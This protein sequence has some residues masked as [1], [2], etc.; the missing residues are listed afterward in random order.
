MMFPASPASPG[1]PGPV[2]ELADLSKDYHGLRPLRIEKL[3]LAEG[4]LVAILG[5]DQPMAET[6]VNLV[7]GATLPDRGEVSIFGRQ[8]SAIRDSADWLSVVDR[9]GIVSERAVL[10]DAL[11]VIQNL[12]IPFTL[13][14]DPVPGD[15]REHAILLAREVGLR[16]ADWLR[17]V[18]ELDAGS[19]IRLRLGRALALDPNVLLLEHANAGIPAS[20]APELGADI[21]RIASKRGCALLAMTAARPFAVAVAPRVLTLDPASGR[22]SERHRNWSLFRRG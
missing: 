15:V 21:Q 18:S 5:L 13:D 12:A 7:T 19:R 6:L 4:E 2:I 8:T 16:E 22:L 3:T 11:S 17:S 9:F 10:L 14:I 20:A 1:F